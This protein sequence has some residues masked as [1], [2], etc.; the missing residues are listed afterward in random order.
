MSSKLRQGTYVFATLIKL[1]RVASNLA[2]LAFESRDN[3]GLIL[4]D[5]KARFQLSLKCA[6][7]LPVKLMYPAWILHKQLVRS[8][9]YLALIYALKLCKFYQAY[10][11]LFK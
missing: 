7:L 9:S 3:T 8:T 11:N 10:D 6:S 4:M 1:R 5:L 2:L